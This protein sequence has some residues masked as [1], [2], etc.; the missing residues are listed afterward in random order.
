MGRSRC[1]V[2]TWLREPRGSASPALSTPPRDVNLALGIRALPTDGTATRAGNATVGRLVLDATVR[3]PAGAPKVDAKLSAGDIVVPEGRFGALDGTFSVTPPAPGSNAAPALALDFAATGI[4]LADPAQARALGTRLDIT[5]RGTMEPG[6]VLD[7]KQARIATSTVQASFEGRIG[8]RVLQG[9]TDF[10]MPDLSAFAGLAGRDI[11]GAAQLHGELD[12]DPSRYRVRAVL[13]G[14]AK[15]LS[16]DIPRLDPL[17]AGSVTV[18]GAVARLPGG[19]AFD[20]FRIDG[21]H[22]TL[23]ADGRATDELADLSANLAIPDLKLA[24]DRLSGRAAAQAKLTGTL[25]KPDLAANVTVE[26]ARMLGRPVPRLALDIVARD[27][28][29][30]LDATV[31]LAGEVDRKP[32]RGRARVTGLAGSEIALQGLDVSVGSVRAT[33]DLRLDAQKLAQGTLNIAA[34]NLDDIAPLILVPAKG[35]LDAGLT[36]TVD[37]GRQGVKAD[38]KAGQISVGDVSLRRLDARLDARDVYGAPSLDADVSVDRLVAA[39]QTFETIRFTSTGSGQG[40]DYV[41]AAKGLGFDLDSKGRIAP[42]PPVAIDIAAFSARRNGTRLALQK[43]ATIVIDKGQVSTKSL[44]LEAGQ[45]RIELA[46]SAGQTLG[47]TLDA[48]AVPLSLANL[49][50]PDLGLDG[51]LDGRVEL[52]GA[53]D[54]PSGSY[55]LNVAGLSAKAIRDAGLPAADVK[56]N[57]TLANGRATLDATVSAPRIG[58]LQASGSLPVNGKGALD[59]RVRGPA[60]LG[61]V[62]TMLA[63]SGRQVT[64][65][66]NLDLTVQGTAASP[67]VGGNASLSG[68]TFNDPIVGIKLQAIE[69]RFVARGDSIAIERFTAATRNGGTIQVAGRVGVDPTAGFPADLRVTGDQRAIAVER[70]RFG[71]HQSRPADHRPAGAHAARLRARRHRVDGRLCARPPARNLSPAPGHEVHQADEGSRHPVADDG[72]GQGRARPEPVCRGVR[73]GH[74]GAEPDFRARTRPECRT[75]RQFAADGNQPRSHRGRRVRVAARRHQSRRAAD[76]PRARQ[77]RLHRAT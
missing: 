3:G 49:F 39:G 56:A 69:G 26:N 74:R 48:R 2:S 65:R 25:R 34:G 53:A 64:G 68:G 75:R 21:R 23:T 50:A 73:S 15:N 45:G 42:G 12:G 4:A 55:R 36:L 35:S 20:G 40:S 27:L 33:G 10:G 5:G 60:D 57:G 32:A 8:R 47:L 1:A 77:A 19:Y 52:T 41:L 66:L 46:G 51:R 76:R 67:K 54:S 7:L 6:F 11:R 43:P 71:H 16:L 63:G 28:T 9:R 18:K 24:D 17:F 58:S 30:A 44:V 70:R 62:N 13:D 14:N 22:V 29:G 72:E 61:I 38:A 31:S 59:L 37:G